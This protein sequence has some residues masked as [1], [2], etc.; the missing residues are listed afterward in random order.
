MFKITG[1]F[2]FVLSL[3]SSPTQADNGVAWVELQPH[4]HYRDIDMFCSNNSSTAKTYFSAEIV[5]GMV[6]KARFHRSEFRSGAQNRKFIELETEELEGFQV[7]TDEAGRYWLVSVPMNER[8]LVWHFFNSSGFLESCTPPQELI[9]IN[10]NTTS[11]V[12]D[13]EFGDGW[14]IRSQSQKASFYGHR[15]DGTYFEV[16]LKFVQKPYGN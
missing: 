4:F 2:L 10:P 15:K 1:Y 11:F 9:D 7:R 16:N 14:L 8:L 12:F 6:T 13:R 5:D 3:I